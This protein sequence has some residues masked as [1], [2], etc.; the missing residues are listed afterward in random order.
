MEPNTQIPPTHT[1]VRIVDGIFNKARIRQ[2]IAVTLT[3]LIGYETIVTN[4]IDAIT[5]IGVYGTVL[6]FYFGDQ[7]E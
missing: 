3:V 7:S 4:N 5:L 6:G 2:F 1:I